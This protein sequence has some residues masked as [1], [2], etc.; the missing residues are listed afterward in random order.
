MRVIILAD[1]NNV[2]PFEIPRQLCE[3]NGERIIDR[4]VRQVKD[5]KR[6]SIYITSHDERFDIAGTKRY[7]HD[8]SWNGEAN[9]GIWLDAFPLDIIVED[10]VILYG[11]CWYT[12]EAIKTMLSYKG[13]NNHFFCTNIRQFKSPYYFKKHDEPLG[14]Y[15]GNAEAF[16]DAVN[17]LKDLQKDAETVFASWQ[18]FRYING[19]DLYTHEYPEDGYTTINDGSTDVDN[20]QDIEL[21]ERSRKL[22]KVRAV[23]GYYDTVQ[24]KQIE[25]KTEFVVPYIRMLELLGN[26]KKKV[27]VAEVIGD[28]DSTEK[29]IGADTLREESE[30]E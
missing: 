9:N 10:T 15:I 14:W 26:N 11:D 16:K 5:N 21:I 2:E 3:I 19:I 17:E 6:R 22:Y 20:V 25:P 29:G 7:E 24:G 12:D 13:T 1:T 4:I 18:V 23:K 28:A 27:V 30:E 8:N